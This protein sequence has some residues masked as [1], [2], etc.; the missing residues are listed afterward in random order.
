MKRRQF[1]NMMAAGTATMLPIHS[2]PLAAASHPKWRRDGVGSIARIGVLTPA[3]DPVPE[4]EAWAMAPEG[5][6]IHVS[7]VRYQRGNPR[8][9]AE[10]PHIDSA[11]ELLAAARPRAIMYAYM[12]S[13]YFLGAAGDEALRI[14]LQRVAAGAPLI[15]SA[16]AASAAL[17][18]VNARRVAIVH[19][20][21]FSEETNDKGKAYFESLGF[22]VVSCVRLLPPRDFQE[23]PPAEVHDKVAA[24]VPKE[25]DAVLIAGNGLR[26]VGVIQALEERLRRP[27][28]T[29]N[30]VTFWAALKTVS[31]APQVSQFGQLFAA[32]QQGAQ[33]TVL[34]LRAR[35]AA[36]RRRW[37]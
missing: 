36:E 6:S 17:R 33:P 18:F 35:T 2:S 7:R 10:P 28:L 11:V 26:A 4:S 16:E 37:A 27:V 22:S 5:V 3:F 24:T 14:R 34:A 15:L 9:F 31:G 19:P 8:L 20:P 23:V 30:Q 32:A 25:A 12:S 13:S 21:W 1:L 29:A